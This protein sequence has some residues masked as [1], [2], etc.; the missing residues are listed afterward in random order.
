MPSFLTLL[1]Y[2]PKANIPSVSRHFHQHGLSLN[3]PGLASD[4]NQPESGKY[5]NPH[6]PPPDEFRRADTVPGGKVGNPAQIIVSRLFMHI[7]RHAQEKT[8]LAGTYNGNPLFVAHTAPGSSVLVES[9]I[10]AWKRL[11]SH[12]L[13]QREAASLIESIVT[14]KD[15]L[16]K[17]CDLPGDDAQTLIDTIHEV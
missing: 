15:E 14:S 16:K 4:R 9:D 13:L 2:T 6:Y 3:H 1:V 12:A 7:H 5:L 10:P 11:L 17:I 8:E